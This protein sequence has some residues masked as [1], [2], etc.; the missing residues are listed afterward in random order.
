V[1]HSLLSYIYIYTVYIYIYVCVCVYRSITVCGT[2]ILHAKTDI[3]SSLTLYTTVNDT[4]NVFMLETELACHHPGFRVWI[5]L[6]G[7]GASEVF[8]NI[9][10]LTVNTTEYD[11][12]LYRRRHYGRGRNSGS[13]AC[14]CEC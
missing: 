2:I 12:N 13:F 4:C 3:R 14:V 5:L 8:N 1:A 10:L 9:C 11:L 6:E 7:C